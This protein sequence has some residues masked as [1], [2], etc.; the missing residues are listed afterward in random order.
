MIPTVE[1]KCTEPARHDASDFLD[2]IL[3]GR[4]RLGTAPRSEA[5]ETMAGRK[6]IA[7]RLTNGGVVVREVMPKTREG[8]DALRGIHGGEGG[9]S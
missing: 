7:T 6:F 8:W 9:A 4:I 5:V 1:I 3:A 2:A